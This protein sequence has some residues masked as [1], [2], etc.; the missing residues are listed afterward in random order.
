MEV[1]IGVTVFLL[2]ALGVYSG[3]EYIF[4]IIYQSRV[5]VIESGI[6]NEQMEIIRNISFYDVGIVNGSPAGILARTVTTTRNN[7]DFTVTRT[8]RNIDDPYDGT[9]GG[10]TNDTSPADYKLAELEV[11]CDHCGQRVP[12]K[13]SSLIAPRYLEGDPDHG[14]L[15]VRVLD[16]R[17]Q[18]IQGAQVHIVATSTDPAVDFID[19]TDNDG[20][21]K[22]VDL[23]QGI[24][25]YSITVTKTGFTSDGTLFPSET[26]PNPVKP[27]A[28]VIAQD[29]TERSFD[30][31]LVSGF[32]VTTMNSLCTPVGNVDFGLMGT[33]LL[34][35]DPDILKVDQSL[36]T[37]GDG[38]LTISNM[39]WDS[40]GFLIDG[41]DIKGAIPALPISLP[42]GVNQPVQLIIGANTANS[43]LINAVDSI[44]GLPLS[45][46][47]VTVSLAGD[48]TV[49]ITGVGHVNQTDWSDGP[50]QVFWTDETAYDSDDGGID[51][52]NPVGDL[53]LRSVGVD[54][55]DSGELTSSIIDLGL[56]ANYLN[57][58]WEPF[59]Q[60]PETGENPVRW[61]IAS[62]ATSTPESW[63]FLGPDG[64]SGSFYDESHIAINDI[65]DGD[66]YFKYKLFLQTATPLYSPV[67]SDFNLTYTNSCQPPGQVYFPSLDAGEYQVTAVKDGYQTAQES[68]TI[69]GDM[70]FTID[71]N[72]D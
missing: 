16:S 64:T 18:P 5:K 33:H 34:G 8:I 4:K 13:L 49:K 43:L 71:L 50:G 45:D 52:N 1:M 14:A 25:V 32:E 11:V 38:S 30:I 3:I 36:S 26:V 72:V 40:Y 65:H 60:K 39:E 37:G 17:G 66:R 22:V 56:G 54:Y 42:A 57:L 41:Y 58:T 31:D 68:I 12:L 28:S 35:T 51:N 7:I 61:Q 46:V 15:F 44:T 20:Y 55:V 27:P 2:F 63:N 47:Q 9:I 24:S 48:E 70:I 6:L 62:S 59:S 19:T 10:E 53:K 21:L 29:V 23:G 69:S 67:I